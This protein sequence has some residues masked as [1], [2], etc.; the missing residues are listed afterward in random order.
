MVLMNE[1]IKVIVVGVSATAVMDAW[2]MLLKLLGIPT[3]N[4]AL[5]GRWVRHLLQGR[6]A[7]T[8]IAKSAP[9]QGELSLGWGIHYVIGIAFSALLVGIQGVAWLHNPTLL[10][11]IAVGMATVVFPLFVMQPAMGAGFLAL[12]TP[13]PLKNCIRSLATHTVFG[14][15]LYLSAALLKHIGV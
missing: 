5:V 14:C 7:H 10:P 8:S 2:S 9:V 3:L 11:A 13:T 15:G 4:Y 6:F 1:I 12:R